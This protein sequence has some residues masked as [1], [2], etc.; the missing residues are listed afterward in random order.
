M[1]LSAG[2]RI[3]RE[4]SHSSSSSTEDSPVIGK[5][6]LTKPEQTEHKKEKDNIGKKHM[7]IRRI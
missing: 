3:S 7:R 4:R 5:K 6:A 1:T 2:S